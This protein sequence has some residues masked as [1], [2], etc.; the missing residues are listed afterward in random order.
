MPL[1]KRRFS[2]ARRD[3]RRLHIH[4]TAPTLTRCSHCGASV[5]T[6]RVCPSC[7]HYRGRSVLAVE[8]EGKK[9]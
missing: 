3:K 1:P 9:D 8:T 6:H 4:L 7:G 5:A 2:R